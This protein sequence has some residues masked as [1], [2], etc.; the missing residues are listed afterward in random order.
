MEKYLKGFLL[1]RGWPLEK[2]HDLTVLLDEAV[3][4]DA[5]FA[6]FED[7]AQTLSQR[8]VEERYPGT[9]LRDV[10]TEEAGQRRVEVADLIALVR[11]LMPPPAAPVP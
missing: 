10:S 7:L 1:A 2:T 3:K 8:Y 5:K 6:R 4:H 9:A 11:S